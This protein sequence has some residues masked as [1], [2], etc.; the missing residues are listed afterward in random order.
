MHEM[1]Q[2]TLLT[3][4]VALAPLLDIAINIYLPMECAEKEFTECKTIF[5][6]RTATDS[7]WVFS[8]SSSSLTQSK[9]VV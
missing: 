7:S 4:M 8:E 5:W 9:A 3:L 1:V 2:K 6:L